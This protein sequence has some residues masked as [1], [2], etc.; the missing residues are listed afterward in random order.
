VDG[1]AAIAVL[2]FLNRQFLLDLVRNAIYVGAIVAFPE[3]VRSGFAE[4]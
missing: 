2:I 1:R 4:G 3:K